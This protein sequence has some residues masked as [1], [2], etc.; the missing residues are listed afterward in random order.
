VGTRS[1]SI[2]IKVE[3]IGRG[4]YKLDGDL[5]P[6]FDVFANKNIAERAVAEFSDHQVSSM[7]NTQVHHLMKWHRRGR[8]KFFLFLL[9]LVKLK[10]FHD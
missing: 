7:S 3:V 5:F 1:I 6:A 2:P 8:L 10:L 4:Y 9:I